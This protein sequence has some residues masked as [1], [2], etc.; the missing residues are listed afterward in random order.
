MADLRCV[1]E[2]ASPVAVLRLTG[3]LNLASGVDLRAALHKA[4]AQ[5]PS[6]IVVDV[7]QL[8][9]DDDLSLT[10]FSGFAGT[11]A[12]LAACPVALCAPSAELRTALQRLAI[13]RA[14]PV[15]ATRQQAVAAVEAGP[16]QRRYRRP[17]AATPGAPAQARKL[18]VA[19]CREWRLPIELSDNAEVVATEMVSNAVRH[20]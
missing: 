14:V 20:A 6:G 16:P 12:E 15:H 18:L 2:D 3:E 19:A 5:Q 17:L 9:V 10:V 8:T 11:A 1:L 7:A 4:L 13:D